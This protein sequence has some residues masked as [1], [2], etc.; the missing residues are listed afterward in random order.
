MTFLTNCSSVIRGTAF[1]STGPNSF[2]ILEDHLFLIDEAGVLDDVIS[3]KDDRYDNILR[4]SEDAGSLQRLKSQQYLLPGFIDTHVHAPQWAQ[5]GKALD[6][7]LPVWLNDYT[8]PLEAAYKNTDFAET[9]YKDLV[10]TLLAN[11]TTTAQYFGSV[12]NEPNKVLAEICASEGQHAYIGKVVMDLPSQCP[13][14]YRDSSPQAAL[15]ATEDFLTYCHNLN[16]RTRQDIVGVVTPRFIPTCSDEVL[17]GLGD[18]ARHY[19]AP[20]Q[21]HCSEGDWEH[22]HVLERTGLSD[23]QAHLKYGLLTNKTTLAHSVYLSDSDAELYKEHG[24]AIA[25]SPLSNI[26]FAGAVCPVK[27][28]LEQG[29]SISLATDISAGYTPSMFDSMRQAILSSRLLSTG[30]DFSKSPI[31]RGGIPA[32]VID[33][34]QAF[35]MATVGGATTLHANAGQFRKGCRFDAF[36]F[37]CLASQSQT[38]QYDTDSLADML[39]KIIFTGQRQN[40]TALWVSGKP[41]SLH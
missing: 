17:Y 2:D 28:R 25:H 39:Q 20:V 8:F 30:T 3:P 23:T 11:G 16:S 41:V 38:R 26:L 36:V 10:R 19:D 6:A 27:R 14:Y 9:I 33:F 34:R 4:R 29:L 7:D 12:H 24:A 21:S 40:I 22:A 35:Y 5:V 1:H 37:D 13:D 15:N 32:S 31:E 18:L